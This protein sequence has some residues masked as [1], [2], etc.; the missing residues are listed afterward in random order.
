MIRHALLAALLASPPAAAAELRFGGKLLL[1][2]GI[3]SID[4]ASGGG[5]TP[6]AVIAGNATRDG[7][8]AS[9]HLSQVVVPD[10]RLTSVG[11]AVG[12]F[13]RVE[14]SY[15]RHGF[16]TG[17]TGAKLGLGRGFTFDQDVLGAKLRL[18]GDAVY[19]QHRLLPQIAVGVQHKRG[20]DGAV[21]R[22]VGA[23]DR[24]GTDVYVAATKILLR[25]SLVLNGTLRLTEANQAGILGHGGPRGDR[26]VQAEASVGYLV[27][28]R[29]VV[30]GE[31]RT[32]PS[33]LAFAREDD[34][35]DLF[36]A[37][38][39][40]PNLTLAAAYV[41]LGSIAAFDDQRGAFLSLQAAF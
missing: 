24:T 28:R 16:D 30:G 14:L 34:W 31:Y 20:R 12:L 17:A 13:D 3:A 15:A 9:A 19:D 40:G 1:T 35:I 25:E 33:N 23:E 27:S 37:Y 41:D 39:L 32:K 6:W 8:G 22:A 2:N 4:G 7:I 18:A 36:A 29:L 10:F 38:A 5:L 26:G 11:A 21:V